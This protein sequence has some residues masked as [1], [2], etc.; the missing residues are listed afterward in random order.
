M[1]T[2]T[3]LVLGSLLAIALG[4][5]GTVV[6]PAATAASPYGSATWHVAPWFLRG[7]C[8]G[9]PTPP[10]PPETPVATDGKSHTISPSYTGEAHPSSNTADSTKVTAAQR[11][12]GSLAA[13]GGNPSAISMAYTG[14]VTITRPS[15]SSCTPGGGISTTMNFTFALSQPRWVDI[16]VTG[17]GRI[18]TEVVINSTDQSVLVDLYNDGTS[19]Q[20]SGRTYLPAGSYTGYMTGSFNYQAPQGPLS[21]SGAMTAR[22]TAPGSRTS[23]PSGKAKPYVALGSAR[24]C[25]HHNLAAKVTSNRSR[26]KTIKKIVITVNGHRVRTIRS[27][28]R[29]KALLL[30]L[31]D[32]SPATVRATVTTV[33]KKH[34]GKVR[35]TRTVGA[36]YRACN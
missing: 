8:D 28:F 5:S 20:N 16:A 11:V 31:A 6:A 15:N 9:T 33:Q 32:G 17:R 34:H 12:T 1:S 30:G 25:G 23:G 36:S 19:V 7:A 13:A 14:K 18:S 24:D 10:L 4:S 26:A 35:K 3:S 22:F 2:R 27:S 21:H 29:G